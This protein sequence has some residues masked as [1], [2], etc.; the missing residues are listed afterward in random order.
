MSMSNGDANGN[1]QT[2]DTQQMRDIGIHVVRRYPATEQR[3]SL[4]EMEEWW[5]RLADPIAKK[6]GISREEFIERMYAEV[7]SGDWQ[8]FADEAHK[9]KWVDHIVDEIHETALVKSPDARRPTATTETTVI[10]VRRTTADGADFESA[11]PIK[12]TGMELYEQIDEDGN[13][14]VRL[15]RPNPVDFYYMHNP[16]N[17]YRFK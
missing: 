12:A 10:P 16:D 14:F 4:E 15:P 8:E 17:Y 13:P 1:Q 3:E 2:D 9:L 5:R 11:I 7:S 6:M